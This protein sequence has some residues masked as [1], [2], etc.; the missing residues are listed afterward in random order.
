MPVIDV[1]SERPV[2]LAEISSNRLGFVIFALLLL[3]LVPILTGSLIAFYENRLLATVERTHHHLQH[4]QPGFPTHGIARNRFGVDVALA[5]IDSEHNLIQNRIDQLWKIQHCVTAVLGLLGILACFYTYAALR[6]IRG[7]VTERDAERAKLAAIFETIN[8]GSLDLHVTVP[9]FLEALRK[10]VP[11]E[12]A[13]FCLLPTRAE[14]DSWD[15]GNEQEDP[16]ETELLRRL[17]GKTMQ[18]T[19]I[20]AHSGPL[21]Q[22]TDENQD[23]NQEDAPD[24]AGA[25][26]VAT[27]SGGVMAELWTT[28]GGQTICGLSLSTLVQPSLLQET[29]EH[30]QPV[31]RTNGGKP[32]LV[33]PL[34]VNN[35]VTG[36]L[37]LQ[38]VQGDFYGPVQQ[39]LIQQAM[40]PLASAVQNAHLYVEANYRAE[41]LAWSMQET[42]HR[43]KNN[44][45]V[46]TAILDMYLMD[47]D[48][49]KV[50]TRDALSHALREVQVIAAVHDLVSE[51]VRVSRVNV[52]HL[53]ERLVPLL[54][55]GPAALGT[56][57][58]ADIESQDLMLPSK[59][60]ATFALATNEI[61]SNAIQHG[62]RGRSAVA[63]HMRLRHEAQHL[64]LDV[65]DDGPGLP[66]DFERRK[67]EHIGLNLVQTLIV[68]DYGGRVDF[69][70]DRGAHVKISIPFA[71]SQPGDLSTAGE[72]GSR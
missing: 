39:L 67:A 19:R 56:R 52:R 71:T 51:D 31:I 50:S 46:V 17:R 10:L 62:G 24:A 49:R 5:D 30:G 7:A 70:N 22:R 41:Q 48:T 12:T 27:A 47:C 34:Y 54:L 23:E 26:T 55:S 63:L 14:I 72:V 61:I 64:C 1:K 38:G 53:M 60:A 21:R 2:S 66:A 65:W 25:H 18:Q 45:Q 9:A 68:R 3:V 28:T 59:L 36:A 11:Y 57:I 16:Q 8:R 13:H 32:L 40:A 33:A 42:Q 6:Q 4:L 43:I 44:L 37:L 29:L 58:D 20:P 69:H 15:A 35:D